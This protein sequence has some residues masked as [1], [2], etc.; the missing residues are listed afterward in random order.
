MDALSTAAEQR[1]LF[2]K[3]LEPFARLAA[4]LHDGQQEHEKKNGRPNGR[5]CELNS[6]GSGKVSWRFGS[7]TRKLRNFLDVNCS[8]TEVEVNR[9][10]ELALRIFGTSDEFDDLKSE[11]ESGDERGASAGC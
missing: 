2:L 7:L 1:G 4:R 8:M 5:H 10:I 3:V 6:D 9:K 11:V